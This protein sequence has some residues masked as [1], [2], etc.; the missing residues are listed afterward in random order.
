MHYLQIILNLTQCF[1]IYCIFKV[2]VGGGEVDQY[3]D[4]AVSVKGKVPLLLV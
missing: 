1:S 3:M 2:N 4:P